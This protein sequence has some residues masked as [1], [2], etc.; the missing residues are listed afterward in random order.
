[1]YKTLIPIQWVSYNKFDIFPYNQNPN[2]PP[3]KN[4]NTIAYAII[5]LHKNNHN[6]ITASGINDS[7][8]KVPTPA[9]NVVTHSNTSDK[10]II[11][12][13]PLTTPPVEGEASSHPF[14]HKTQ[15]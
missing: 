5:H 14:D 2:A 7:S 15:P 6:N 13:I 1:M 3:Q 12:S 10:S 8:L 4:V 11:Q 9:D